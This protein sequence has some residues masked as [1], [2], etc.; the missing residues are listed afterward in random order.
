METVLVEGSVRMRSEASG[1]ALL[2]EP[3]EK[4]SQE[5]QSGSLSKEA[6]NVGVYTAW[7]KGR[8]V[9]RKMRFDHILTKLERHYNVEFV[10]NNRALGGELFNASFAADEPIT[11]LLE[12][13]KRTHAIKYRIQNNTIIIN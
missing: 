12:Y 9:F 3:G 2:L 1:A 11:A 8:L 4:G 10:N 5:K 13:F 6:V 7:M